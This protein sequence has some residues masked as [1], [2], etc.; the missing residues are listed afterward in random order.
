MTNPFDS[1][2]PSLYDVLTHAP[3]PSGSLPLTPEML[4]ERPSGDLFGWTQN[5]GMGW[6]PSALGG[7]EFLM[8]STH[9]GIRAPDGTPIALGYHTGHWEVGLLMEAAAAEFIARRRDPVR[10]LLHRSV[11]RPL[12]G[13]AGDVRQPAVSQRRRDDLPPADPIAADAPRRARRRHLR[14]GAAGDDDGA[15]RRRAICRACS[16]PAASRCCRPKARTPAACRRS[17]SASRTAR[18]RSSRRPISAAARARHPAAAAS[19]SARRRRRRSSAK[20]SGMSLG[21]S[22]LAPVRPADLARHGAALG[23]RARCARGARHPTSRDILTDASLQQ[24]DGRARGVRRLHEPAPAR[25]GD[26]PRRGP[27]A[28]RPPRDWAA[29]NR[30]VPRLVDALPNGPRNHPTVQVFLA[31]GVPEVMLHLRRAGLLD[32]SRPHRRA[33]C[34]LGEQLDAWEASE[35]RAR[36]RQRL[37]DLRRRRS[38]RRDHVAGSGARRAA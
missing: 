35:R 13:H 30:S 8:L 9:G 33:A 24:R 26:R 10:R 4:R 32:T 5:A 36:L 34:T 2:D 22:A 21:H 7:R 25:A 15:R 3:G 16:C 14:Q 28:A 29:I 19:F 27:A 1:S 18:S 31:G 38:R 20:R 11:R 12:A 23:A 37:R 17:A 6:K